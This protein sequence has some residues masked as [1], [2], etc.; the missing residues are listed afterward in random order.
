MTPNRPRVVTRSAFLQRACQQ[1]SLAITALATIACSFAHLAPTP[2][3]AQTPDRV[4][5]GLT[6]RY[7]GPAIAGGRISDLEV[8]PGTQS[9]IYVGAA[10]GGVWESVNHGTT[11]KPIF[12]DQPNLSVGDI[13]LAP[14]DPLEIWVGTGEANNRNSSPWGQGVYHS[15]DGG[16]TW[17]LAGLEDT[18]HV[19]RVV[20][21]PTDPDRVWVAAA[22]HLFGPNEERG[23][24]RTTDRGATWQKVLYIDAN[25]GAIDLAMDPS[26]PRILYAATYQRQRRAHG[27]V[28]AGPAAAFTRAPTAAT[29]G[30]S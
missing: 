6:W 13:A 27:F 7:I 26:D 16:K 22:G 2:L 14:S 21:H 10:S 8:V 28:G 12:D 11:W 9:H 25:T 24:F 29:P 19:G 30:A 17:R 1:V 5:A 4:A 3:A 20:V 15:S 23:V 18:R